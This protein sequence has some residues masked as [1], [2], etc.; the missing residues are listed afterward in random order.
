MKNYLLI[1]GV[2]L[3]FLFSSCETINNETNHIL[4][5]D[6]T[7]A[8]TL[9]A[10]K[11]WV[12]EGIVFVHADLTIEAG[13][14]IKF[15]QGASLEVGAYEFGSLVAEGTEE[16]P[17]VFTS[18][19]SNPSPGDWQCIYFGEK[20]SSAKSKLTYC[21]IEYAGKSDYGA[22]GIDHTE[23][24][25][26][27][28]TIRHAKSIGISLEYNGKF[29]SCENNSI[30]NVGTHAIEADLNSVHTLAASNSIPANGNY[31]IHVYGN[32]VISGSVSWQKFDAPYIMSDNIWLD[33]EL[34]AS[35]LT[36]S[37]GC[38]LKFGAEKGIF[39]G[40]YAYA[41][42]VANGTAEAPITFTSSAASPSAGNWQAIEFGPHTNT[43]TSLSY[44]SVL[45]AGSNIDYGMVNVLSTDNLT[46]SNCTFA[47]SLTNAIYIEYA[48]PTLSN[49]TFE[50]IAGE[51]V[52]VVYER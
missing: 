5:A 40:N 50:N 21:I 8:T 13:T 30:S 2:L 34:G 37:P 27:N 1:L 38:I 52:Y 22:L 45:N 46:I 51:N 35:E 43:G 39:V 29:I 41:K 17:I 10:D 42:L 47:N 14:T 24:S 25:M 32:D 9:T 15:M 4:N 23:L 33:A 12:V 18:G 48:N 28:C 31:G 3:L 7:V 16:K 26:N 20:N 19:A 49:N 6:I 36:I 44:C 11:E